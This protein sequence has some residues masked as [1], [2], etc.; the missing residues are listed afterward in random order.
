MNDKALRE[1]IVN[2]LGGEG[3]H[4][5]FDEAIAGLPKEFRSKKARGIPHTPWRLLEHMRIAQRDILE[6]CTNPKYKEMKW[7][8]DYWPKGDGPE[9]DAEWKRSVESFHRDIERMKALVSNPKTDLFAKIPWGDGQTYL[10]E[11]L[12]VADHNAYHVGELVA[13]RRALGAWKE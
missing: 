3:A 1:H 4:L 5:N 6:F 9:N 8:E 11:A 10:R 7:P 12:L 2:L 13:V